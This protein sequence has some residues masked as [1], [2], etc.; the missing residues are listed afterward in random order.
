MKMEIPTTLENDIQEFVDHMR[1]ERGFS[2][3]TS[4][5]YLR[6]LT[7]YAAWLGGDGVLT[8]RAITPNHVLRYAHELRSAHYNPATKDKIYSPTSVARKLSAIRSWH[9]FLAREK[10]YSDPS[11][12]MEA[13]KLPRHLPRVLGK[14]QVRALLASPKSDSPE[15][16]RDKAILE[17]LY[18]SGLRASELCELREGAVD[19][20]SGFVRCTGKGDKERMV[21][22]GETARAAIENYLSF[23]RPKLLENRGVKKGANRR[24]PTV[25]FLGDKGQPLSRATLY[26]MVRFHADRAA[27]P[28]WVTPHTLRHSFATHLL[29]NGADLRA[30]QEMLG[31]VDI[32]TTQI[33]TH[34]ET[35][36]LRKSYQKAH[37]RA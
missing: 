24:L 30:I 33:Y 8:A 15:G 11:S 13:A 10:E 12:K 34:V 20:K 26:Q 25:I 36:H 32:V 22:V 19:M 29:Q 7:Q 17:L 5:A 16:V 18:S 37:P 27:L 9:R 2:Q 14:D 6:D 23:S 31:H 3:N 1:V 4:S 35:Q 21:P 28:D